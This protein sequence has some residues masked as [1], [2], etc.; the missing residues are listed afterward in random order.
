MLHRLQRFV[1][2]PPA[3]DRLHRARQ[4]V[5]VQR[6]TDLL[7]LAAL[8]FAQQLAGAAYLQ[9]VGG[10]G[11]AG[12]QLAHGLYRFQALLGITGQRLLARHHQVGVSAMVRAADAAPQLM[13]LRQ[14][15][16]VGAVD[17]HGVGAGHVDAGFDDGGGDQDV[18]ALVVEI[19]HHLLQFALAHLPVGKAHPRLRHD[20]A[21]GFGGLLDVLDLVVQVVDLPAAPQFAQAGFL[22]QRTVPVRDE[23]ADRQAQGRRR[24]DDRQVTQPGHAHVQGARNRC[25]GEGQQVHL[26]TQ[27]FHALLVAHAKAVF[28]VDDHQT[29]L[30]EAHV[31]LQQAV[32]ADHDIDV[33][34]FQFTHQRVEFLAS[35]QARSHADLD[36]PV[37]E[38][39]AEILVVLL[40]QQGGGGQQADLKTV[41]G[42]REAG[43]QRDFGLAEAHVAAD[44]PVHRLGAGQIGQHLVDG[45]LLIWRGLEGEALAEAPIVQLV[46][47]HR[48]A[49]PCRPAGLDLQQFGGYIAGLFT[50]LGA[51][52]A[53]ALRAHRVQR[54]GFAFGA[55]VAVHLAQRGH[56]HI[57]LVLAGVLD[58]QI[59]LGETTC[60]ENLQAGVAAH[61]VLHMH[62]RATDG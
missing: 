21:D 6:E 32:G 12:T 31:V 17:D 53:P 49:D 60:I 14:T 46:Q 27:L 42:R 51:G 15:Q 29:Q 28:L 23:G 48:L 1:I 22:H 40:C 36:R 2:D 9:I 61:A 45:L 39:V 3:A 26:G 16:L 59:F 52:L 50:G 44:H 55:G 18:E 58:D 13:Q 43:A 47:R 20:A 33:A 34:A 24:G 25:G 10:Q 8:T 38:A 57:E 11:E 41:L 54:R 4:Q 37:R 7:H 19:Q 5:R 30:L 56:R 35:A 62:Y